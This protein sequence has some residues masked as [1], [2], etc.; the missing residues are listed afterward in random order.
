MERGEKM[1][2]VECLG[3]ELEAISHC[4][5]SWLHCRV[6]RRVAPKK[7]EAS[8]VETQGK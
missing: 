7:I 4:T 3:M 8:A 6:F 1:I 2:F 5:C